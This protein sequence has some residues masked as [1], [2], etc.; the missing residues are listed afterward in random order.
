MKKNLKKELA[1]Q[2]FKIL[3]EIICINIEELEKN[4]ILFKS[5]KWIKNKNQHSSLKRN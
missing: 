1:K 4:K 2:W 5:E 3:E